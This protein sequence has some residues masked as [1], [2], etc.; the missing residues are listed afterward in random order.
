[1]DER[2]APFAAPWEA[3][4]FAM[5]HALADR[6]V[7][8]WYEFQAALITE[9]AEAPERPYYERWSDALDHVLAAKQVLGAP[10]R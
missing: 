5:A 1:M 7:F 4:V 9:T 10:S 3:R 6:G 8:H 2:E